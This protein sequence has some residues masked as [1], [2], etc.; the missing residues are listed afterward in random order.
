MEPFVILAIAA[1]A[2]IVFY[3]VWN[4]RSRQTGTPPEDAQRRSDREQDS[5]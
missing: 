2:L 4:N 3:I 1:V 5:P